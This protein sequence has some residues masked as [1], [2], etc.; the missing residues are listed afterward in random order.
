MST[1]QDSTFEDPTETTP[2]EV[3]HQTTGSSMTSSSSRGAAFYFQCATLVINF[4]G[5]AANGLVLYAMVA[6][7]QHKKHVL[8]FNQN[9]F[10]IVGCLFSTVVIP[11]EFNNIYLSE[12]GGYWLCL[13]FFS[14]AGSMAAY[15]GSLINLAAISIERYLKI[16]H[17]TWAK[18][19]LR[20][21]VIYSA[22]AFAW[23]SGTV[24]AAAVIVPTTTVVNGVCFSGHFFLSQAGR[25]AYTIWE[26]LSFY[27]II[28]LIVIFCYGR[29]VMTL[30]SQ[31]R[32]MAAHGNQ[33]SNPAQDPSSKIQISVIKTM[34]LVSGLFAVTYG[35]FYIF[36][37]LSFH[38]DI[39]MDRENRYIVL[40]ISYVYYCI[41]P[42]IYVT[43]YDPVKRVLLDLIPCKKNN[44]YP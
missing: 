28:L 39:T 7:K 6:S 44:H 1:G 8:I 13:T 36:M 26:F 31:A 22:V 30:R 34:I 33:G 5:V 35:P 9:V 3:T 41:N 14:H 10:D 29:I 38:P 25:R 16:V 11:V 42:F 17:H 23:I 32:V 21:W 24:I 2:D 18:K 15:F 4:V 27:V 37:L 40:S 20:N 43:K 19:K 12:T